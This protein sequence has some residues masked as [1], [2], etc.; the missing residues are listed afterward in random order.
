MSEVYRDWAR[1]SLALNDGEKM[2]VCI[3]QLQFPAFHPRKA[4]AG[5]TC[6]TVHVVVKSRCCDMW[7][8]SD[9]I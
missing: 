6:K 8:Y 2:L 5:R 3:W 7:S 4:A 9:V 1:K